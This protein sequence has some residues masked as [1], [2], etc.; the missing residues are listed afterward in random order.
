MLSDEWVVE[1]FKLVLL[2]LELILF[3]KQVGIDPVVGLF[4]LL[5]DGVL[6]R[7]SELV[8]QLLVIPRG[9]DFSAV[10]IKQFHG[11]NAILLLLVLFLKLLSI[12]Q[13]FLYFLLAQSSL[14]IADGDAV[15]LARGRFNCKYFEDSIGVNVKGDINHGNTLQTWSYSCQFKLPQEVII[16]DQ[17]SFALIDLEKFLIVHCCID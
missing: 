4:A 7:L 12:Q 16:F 17:R 5:L 9:P 15:G 13:H 14:N 8:L 10:Y 6:V 3:G 2:V 11:C 1:G